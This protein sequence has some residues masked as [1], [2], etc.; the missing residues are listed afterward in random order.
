MSDNAQVSNRS[1]AD[2]NCSDCLYYRGKSKYRR[3]GCEQEFCPAE[4]ERTSITTK[5]EAIRCRE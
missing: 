5:E 3:S 1:G 4:A 2:G